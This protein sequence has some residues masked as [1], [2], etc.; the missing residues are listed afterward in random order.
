MDQVFSVERISVYNRGSWEER[1]EGLN[2]R[3]YDGNDQLVHESVLSN[4]GAG[5]VHQENIAQDTQV[6]RIWIG[7]DPGQVNGKADSIVTIA[8]LVLV[9]DY[10]PPTTGPI[11]EEVIT[12]P[13]SVAQYDDA[14][15]VYLHGFDVFGSRYPALELKYRMI[16]ADGTMGAEQTL[17]L[18][19]VWE[20][21]SIILRKD[22]TEYAALVVTA[23]S[24][25]EVIFRRLYSP[26]GTLDPQTQVATL[27]QNSAIELGQ[28]LTEAPMI[29]LPD[30]TQFASLTVGTPG[31]A[32]D[33]D[34]G[35]LQVKSEINYP[36]VSSIQ[37][38][39]LS[40]QTDFPT[41]ESKRSLYVPLKSQLF[42]QTTGLPAGVAHYL[43]EI[44][45]DPH[46]LT[47]TDDLAISLAAGEIKVHRTDRKDGSTN[48]LGGGGGGLGQGTGTMDVDADGNIYFSN[49]V[50]TDVVRFNVHTATF[51]VPPTDL[52]RLSNLYLPTDDEILGNGDTVKKNGRWQTYRM[53]A[54]MNHSEPKRMLYG[55]TISKLVFSGTLYEWSALFTL[56]TDHWDDPVAFAN[57][58][59]L[60]VGSWPSA[61][62][63]FYDTLPVTDGPLRRIQY[64]T[65]Y[66]NT[67]YAKDYPNSIGGPWRVD[68]TSDNMVDAFGTPET[69]NGADEYD[70]GDNKPRDVKPYNA[71]VGRKIHFQDYGLLTMERKNLSYCLTGTTD[72]SLTGLIEVSYDAIAH[73][74][75]NESGF[76]VLL[77]NTGG[78]SLA[79]SYMSIPLPGQQG[80]LLGVGGNTATIWPSSMSIRPRPARWIKTS[81]SLIPLTRM[82]S[83]Q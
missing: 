47:G 26:N 51:E 66:G 74:L 12:E 49:S 68:I 41:D 55:R 17:D 71:A 31:R 32:F 78:P 83:Y 73:M 82:L 21:P 58:F 44:P 48:I 79:P 57:E 19:N 62:Y 56:P 33:L 8:E 14:V 75:E 22:G 16:L 23:S 46:W 25:A 29:P 2:L 77:D 38:C 63:S 35:T 1:L 65:S 70:D 45:L 9:E 59:R 10:V 3:V 4:P 40:R 52:L 24:G 60:L 27:A 18:T 28:F 11:A 20:K 72:S 37:L 30:R 61:Q 43:C 7:L 42:N 39:A 54:S 67:V 80:K 69:W 53:V 13:V 34:A 5:G 81:R 50:P 76:A 36:Q 15:V 64:F 6:K